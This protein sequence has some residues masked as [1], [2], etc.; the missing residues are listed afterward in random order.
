[1]IKMKLYHGSPEKLKIIIPQKA[2]GMMKFQHQKAIFLTRSFKQASLYAISKSLKGRTMFALPPHKL[3]IVGRKNRPKEGYV[4]EVNVKA[5]KGML[6]NYEYSYS[7]PIKHF[8]ILK[9]SPK[10]H[11][12]SIIYV[13]TKEELLNRINKK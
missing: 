4:Y 3:I 5:K 2:D 9:V 12:K 7:K 10:S 6:G 8:K 11:K 1:M 13:N